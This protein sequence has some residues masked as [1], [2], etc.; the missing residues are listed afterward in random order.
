MT[1]I[2]GLIPGSSRR[3]VKLKLGS[4]LQ[5]IRDDFASCRDGVSVF[6]AHKQEHFDCKLQLLCAATDY[7]GLE[8]LYNIRGA[9]TAPCACLRCWHTGVRAPTG[10]GIGS[11]KT[12]YANHYTFLPPKVAAETG[13]SKRLFEL[14]NPSVA[15][16]T[17]NEAEPALRTGAQLYEGMKVCSF[18]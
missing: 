2:I 7:R 18:S 9:P 6:D 8:D 17:G 4:F 5:L 10:Q 13:S 14:N 1:T 11:V 12:L 16:R 15:D 3:D